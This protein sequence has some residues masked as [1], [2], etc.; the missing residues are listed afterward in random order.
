VPSDLAAAYAFVPGQYLTLR[1]RLDGQDL[2]RSYSIC[3][4]PDEGELRIAVKRVEGGPFSAW[5]NSDLR[6]G[7]L[8]EVMTPTGRFGI[9]RGPG[10][11][12]LY[13][14]IVAGSG[15]TPILSIVRGVL[16]GEPTSRFFLLY[17]NRS[18]AEVLFGE[19]LAEL[20]DRYMERLSVFHVLSREEQDVAVL[21]GRLD[22]S[23][24]RQLLCSLVPAA[25]IDHVLICGPEGMAEEL[26]PVLESLGIP[27]ARI[28]VE[29][30]VSVLGGRPRVK[31]PAVTPALASRMAT[32]IYDGKR[33]DV[34]VAEGEAILDAALRAGL[35]LPY[36]CKGGMCCTCRAKVIEG[37]AV[38]EVNYSLE[39]WEQQAGYVLT[40]QAHP[41]SDRI[42]VDYD[43]V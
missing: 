17:G 37:A 40:C 4:G 14:G 21:N 38:M 41:Q 32:L 36:A 23:K 1:A 35:D 39:A 29:R 13:L 11:A 31:P 3:S 25:A 33:R 34:P 8:I 10:G 22:A 15:I 7:D 19:A 5:V 24:V 6:A 2:R 27:R 18:T 20:K 12:R 43:Q 30:F 9:P 16:V 28:H 42:I 26:G